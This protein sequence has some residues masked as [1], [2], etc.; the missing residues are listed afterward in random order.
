VIER[1]FEA[2]YPELKYIPKSSLTLRPMAV[3]SVNDRIVFQAI[4]NVVA[5]RARPALAMVTNR[6]SFANALAES[7]QKR[8]FI[9]WKKQYKLFQE[10]F[11]GLITE[12][13]CWLA[14]TDAAAF[15]ETVDHSML[16]DLLCRNGF[17]DDQVHE[18]LENYLPIWS[19]VK[20]G[21]PAK[22]GVPQ[23]CLASDLFADLF[24]YEF[25]G[26]LAVQEYHYLRYVD[27]IRVLGDTKEAVQ[28]GLIHIDMTLKSIGVLLQTKKTTVRKIESIADEV[29]HLAAQL[30]EIDRRLEEADLLE[31][32]PPND[33][34]LESSLKNVAMFGEDF[35]HTEQIVQRAE[36]I[37]EELSTIFW[38]S[39]CS[40]KAND[41]YAFAERHMR[42]ALYRLGIFI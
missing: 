21:A 12:G 32:T 17:L 33:P 38:K 25:D 28:R 26:E 24:L 13:N 4:A 6:Q 5:E 3:L 41:G 35:Q 15:Y 34:I 27:D 14:E 19:S 20:F 18:R 7:G 29:D 9:P 37:Q 11:C 31:Q 39:I 2:N 22:R 36:S 8:M 23:G 42:F 10:K 1:T 30:S 16:F 40:T